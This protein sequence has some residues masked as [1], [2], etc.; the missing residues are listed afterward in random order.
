MEWNCG[1]RLNFGLLWQRSKCAENP[2]YQLFRYISYL[3]LDG[4]LYSMG[5]GEADETKP[6]STIYNSGHTINIGPTSQKF[7]P[8]HSRLMS[9]VNCQFCRLQK[10]S[11]VDYR[12]LVSSVSFRRLQ[13]TSFV[14]SASFRFVE[15]RKPFRHACPKFNLVLSSHLTGRDSTEGGGWFESPHS[16]IPPLLAEKIKIYSILCCYFS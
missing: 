8:W 16:A 3:T 11:F 12:K 5:R 2:I 7:E 9:V 10:P 13:E 1:G 4:F 15:Y 6:P 14:S